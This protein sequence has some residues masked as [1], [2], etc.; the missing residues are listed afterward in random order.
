MFQKLFNGKLCTWICGYID[1]LC[2]IL[3][4]LM[5]NVC[6]FLVI[7]ILLLNRSCDSLLS[8]T[9]F[10]ISLLI[11]VL[12]LRSLRAS[13]LITWWAQHSWVWELDVHFASFF[14]I[15]TYFETPW[16][17]DVSSVVLHTLQIGFCFFFVY[18]LCMNTRTDEYWLFLH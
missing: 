9:C 4:W 3:F 8:F 1:S 13:Y 18:K 2:Y 16:S 12:T 7:D 11:R 5:F 14:R 17:M 10:Q 6:S 15:T